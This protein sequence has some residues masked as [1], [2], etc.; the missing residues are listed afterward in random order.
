[1][2]IEIYIRSMTCEF[3]NNLCLNI[4]SDTDELDG[5]P[6]L[7]PILSTGAGCFGVTNLTAATAI[8][9]KVCGSAVKISAHEV[10]GLSTGTSTT[11]SLYDGPGRPGESTLF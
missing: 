6:P 4:T 3:C 9:P 5:G 10:S 11:D 2:G 1:M 7:L 8:V